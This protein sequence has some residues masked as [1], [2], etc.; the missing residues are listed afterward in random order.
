[1]PSGVIGGESGVPV[2]AGGD[3]D[4]VAPGE[5][6]AAGPPFGALARP[7]ITPIPKATA[8]VTTIETILVLTGA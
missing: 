8:A 3:T 2:P 1:M 5:G 4:D 7:T 6:S